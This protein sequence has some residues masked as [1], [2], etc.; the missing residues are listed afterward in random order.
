MENIAILCGW[1]TI[2]ILGETKQN[3]NPLPF[4]EVT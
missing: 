3:K 1:K 2:E 4:K